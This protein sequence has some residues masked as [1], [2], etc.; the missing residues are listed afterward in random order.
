MCEH[1][2]LETAIQRIETE[3]ESA[4]PR[5]TDNTKGREGS[6][7][8][9]LDAMLSSLGTL[10]LKLSFIVGVVAFVGVIYVRGLALVGAQIIGYPMLLAAMAFTLCLLMPL[11]WVVLR[12][13]W[14]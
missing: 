4:Q 7:T 12:K 5:R 13:A 10:L 8:N 14:I 6:E 1:T 9:E 3:W 11:S 2:A